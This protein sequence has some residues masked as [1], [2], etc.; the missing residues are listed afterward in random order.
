MLSNAQLQLAT[1][2]QDASSCLIAQS[3]S[4]A[5]AVHPAR[6]D[7]MRECHYGKCFL[8]LRISFRPFRIRANHGQTIATKKKI[9]VKIETDGR[10]SKLLYKL[11]T[12]KFE[13]WWVECHLYF[14]HDFHILPPIFFQNFDVSM[15]WF[16]I[17]SSSF[18]GSLEL[19]RFD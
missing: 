19:I 7:G 9:Y 14:N 5:S 18:K 6:W 8:K 11:N 4:V 12:K 15:D 16:G 1:H 3:E 13:V 17:H 2:F 10:W